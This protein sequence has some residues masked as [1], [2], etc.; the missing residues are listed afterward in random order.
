MSCNVEQHAA[1]AAQPV[2]LEA[3]ASPVLPEVPPSPGNNVMP[4]L[5]PK[6]TL[7]PATPPSASKLSVTKKH[8]TSQML[9]ETLPAFG[10]TTRCVSGEG[11]AMY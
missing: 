1:I 2:R 10:S 6:V 4:P 7:P 11:D 3:P 5:G 8:F 9:H